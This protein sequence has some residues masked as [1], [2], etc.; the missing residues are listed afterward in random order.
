MAANQFST[1]MPKAK[2][3]FFAL[4]LST[5][6]LLVIFISALLL[7][8][9]HRGFTEQCY[10]GATARVFG[11]PYTFLYVSDGIRWDVWYGSNL[12]AFTF[13]AFSITIGFNWFNFTKDAI[14]YGV[15]FAFLYYFVRLVYRLRT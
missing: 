9:L 3:P 12:Y 11:T 10:N 2:R 6:L 8:T 13:S 7:I 5:L 15:L 14:L 4:S 1:S